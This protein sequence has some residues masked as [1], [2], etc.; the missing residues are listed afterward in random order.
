VLDRLM[1]EHLEH[2]AETPLEELFV[3]GTD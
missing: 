1:R 2:L 3:A